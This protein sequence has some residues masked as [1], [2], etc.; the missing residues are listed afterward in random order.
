MIVR[1]WKDCHQEGNCLVQV[2]V[3]SKVNGSL[4]VEVHVDIKGENVNV[5]NLPHTA[6]KESIFGG[7]AR[8]LAHFMK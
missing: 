7:D 5:I 8:A 4:K 3:K 1:D 2:L 6:L